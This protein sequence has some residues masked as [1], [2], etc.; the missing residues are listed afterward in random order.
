MGGVGGNFFLN[1]S[2]HILR[3]MCAHCDTLKAALFQYFLSG[4]EFGKPLALQCVT[5]TLPVTL[6]EN[7][8]A[9][10]RRFSGSLFCVSELFGGLLADLGKNEG[11]NFC[12]WR[13]ALFCAIEL[14][15]LGGFSVKLAA[16]HGCGFILVLVR[17][18]ALGVGFCGAGFGSG[19]GFTSLS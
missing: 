14:V 16:D 12:V 11:F 4:G 9:A 3:T 19:H 13:G 10:A 15:A 6:Q 8:K 18:A 5:V 17:G 7:K 1:L 2:L